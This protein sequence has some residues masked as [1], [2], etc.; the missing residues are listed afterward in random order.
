VQR[1]A[2]AQTVRLELAGDGARGVRGLNATPPPAAAAEAPTSIAR[3]R[4]AGS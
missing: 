2:A 4:R 1:P 3:R